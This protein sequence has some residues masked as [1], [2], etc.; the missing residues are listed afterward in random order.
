[1]KEG[2]IRTTQQNKANTG[3]DKE[4]FMLITAYMDLHL[5][6]P[7]PIVMGNK[8][9]MYRVWWESQI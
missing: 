2:M 5:L 1:M 6:L 7:G 9:A 4:S 8:V 3:D